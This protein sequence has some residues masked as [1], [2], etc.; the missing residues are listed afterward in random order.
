VRY[1]GKHKLGSA[2][3]NMSL[4]VGQTVT[5]KDKLEFKVND[6]LKLAMTGVFDL[7]EVVT[8]GESANVNMGVTAELKI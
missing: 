6:K 1:G 7:Q 5:W 8:K 2:D 4:L 3:W